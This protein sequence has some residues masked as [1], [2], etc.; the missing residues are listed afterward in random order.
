MTLLT[1]KETFKQVQKHLK[2]DK[3]NVVKKKIYSVKY[4][5]NKLDKIFSLM[6]R[7]HGVCE[8]CGKSGPNV[9]LQAAH[10]ITRS[11]LRLRWD[12][13]NVMTLCAG[14]HLFWHKNPLESINWFNGVYP[15]RAKYVLEHKDEIIKDRDY[16]EMYASFKQT[17]KI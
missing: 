12:F 8:M 1:T 10:V 9:H 3:H 15:E 14:C 13:R 11:N 4:W 2:Y 6:V 16:Q 5:K 17:M 7:S